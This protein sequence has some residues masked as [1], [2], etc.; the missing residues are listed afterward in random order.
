LGLLWQV[1]GLVGACLRQATPRLKRRHGR[2]DAVASTFGPVALVVPWTACE[3]A[4][5]AG[6]WLRRLARDVRGVFGRAFDR[7]V[8]KA[9]RP[10]GDL[11]DSAIGGAFGP[12]PFW[13]RLR[14]LLTG[15]SQTRSGLSWSAVGATCATAAKVDQRWRA[16]VRDLPAEDARRL[17]RPRA[18]HVSG[19]ACGDPNRPRWKAAGLRADTR[20]AAGANLLAAQAGQCLVFDQPRG[21]AVADASGHARAPDRV[22]QVAQVLLCR[23]EAK[24]D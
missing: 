15:P 12:V 1:R 2:A 7:P 3:A 23:Q 10:V 5:E 18:R 20:A 21:E 11:R 24:L 22:L 17:V 13:T 9:V 8:Y 16:W 4:R 14:A 19:G 6:V